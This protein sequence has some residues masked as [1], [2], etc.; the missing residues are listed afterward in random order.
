MIIFFG[1]HC[2]KSDQRKTISC[3]NV[4]VLTV[5][6]CPPFWCLDVA[7]HIRAVTPVLIDRVQSPEMGGCWVRVYLSVLEQKP[8]TNGRKDVH[9]VKQFDRFSR[10]ESTN[11]CLFVEW[12][13][14]TSFSFFF[15]LQ[16]SSHNSGRWGKQ[17]VDPLVRLDWKILNDYK[18][19]SST[20]ES[21]LRDVF[22]L[23]I[24]TKN[25]HIFTV[26]LFSV[27]VCVRRESRVCHN[28]STRAANSFFSQCCKVVLAFWPG[29]RFRW[30][31]FGDFLVLNK[32]F[33]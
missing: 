9:L 27:R 32:A 25:N 19:L 12:I 10:P 18:T 6:F 14:T 30:T 26:S 21:L 31:V 5:V 29:T 23:K 7:S 4:F 1:S 3:D 8:P 11:A 13:K 22:W 24:H 28:F 2:L 16:S 20:L 15:P 17:K 33:V